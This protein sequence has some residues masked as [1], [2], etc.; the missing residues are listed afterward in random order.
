M[1][2]PDPSQLPDDLALPAPATRTFGEPRFH[3]E[4]DI[5]AIAFA[6]DGTLCPWTRSAC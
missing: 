1:T 2:L 3:T 6:A 5:A 4:G